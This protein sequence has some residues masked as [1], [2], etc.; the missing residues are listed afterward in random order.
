ME[1]WSRVLVPNVGPP[2]CPVVAIFALRSIGKPIAIAAKETDPRSIELRYPPSADNS[3]DDARTNEIRPRSAESARHPNNRRR[4][5]DILPC[6]AVLPDPIR[7][8]ES[9]SLAS[10]LD[11]G[12]P[13]AI[14]LPFPAAP[15]VRA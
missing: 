7:E 5:F 8:D 14:L 9:N 2:Q 6:P 11:P 13:L 10:E 12:D 15:I 4:L 3:I 1:R